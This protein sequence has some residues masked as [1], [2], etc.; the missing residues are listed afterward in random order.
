MPRKRGK[1]SQAVDK[2][3]G[4][5]ETSSPF[6]TYEPGGDRPKT[7]AGLTDK[8]FDVSKRLIDGIPSSVSAGKV[9]PQQYDNPRGFPGLALV[10]FGD[11]KPKLPVGGHQHESAHQMEGEAKLAGTGRGRK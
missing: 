6:E 7:F 1:S 10:Q 5:Y 4:Y 9:D 2:G 3:R 11:Q 8:N